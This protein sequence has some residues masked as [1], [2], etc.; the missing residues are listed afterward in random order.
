MTPQL[1]DAID[2]MADAR[3]PKNWLYDLTGVEISW[4]LPSLGSWISSYFD[5][6]AQ[7]NTWYKNGRPN[8]YWLTGFFNPQGFLTCVK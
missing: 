3:V 7:L 2:A 4:M 1:M 6:Y 5:R 8:T